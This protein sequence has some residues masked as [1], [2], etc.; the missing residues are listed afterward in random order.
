M[1][2]KPKIESINAILTELEQF[3]IAIETNTTPIVTIQD[4][5]AALDLAYR[6]MRKMNDS[7]NQVE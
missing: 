1:F 6:I 5:Y 7:I 3:A 4:G 2:D